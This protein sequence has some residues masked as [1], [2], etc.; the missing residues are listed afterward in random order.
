LLFKSFNSLPTWELF[1]GAFGQVT[2]AD[3]DFDHYNAVIHKAWQGGAGQAIP[4][5]CLTRILRVPWC[6]DD[7]LEHKL[8]GAIEDAMERNR[9]I[10]SGA[11]ATKVLLNPR[12]STTSCM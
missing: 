10:M 3:F 11:T 4:E 1:E 2:W 9:W 8:R 5:N 6:I 7:P 12:V